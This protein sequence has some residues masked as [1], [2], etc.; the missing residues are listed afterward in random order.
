MKIVNDG[1]HEHVERD[2]GKK[3]DRLVIISIRDKGKGIDKE[4][5]PRLFNKF[6]TNS[7]HGT[8]LGLYIANNIIEAHG[9]QIWAQNNKYEKGQPCCLVYQ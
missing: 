6:V 2:N 4:I 9:G 3:K 8:G 1:Y 7:N 5:L